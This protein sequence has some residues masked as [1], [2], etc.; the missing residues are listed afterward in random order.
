MAAIQ[1]ST[2]LV[3]GI[4]IQDTVDKLIALASQ[5]KD[6]LTTRTQALQS[7]QVAV[8]QLSSLLVAFQFEV[9]QLGTA[10]LFDSRQVTSSDTSALTAAVSENGS[11]AQGN[12][13]FTPVQTASTQ[14]LLSQSFGAGD[15]I[16]AGTLTFGAGGFVNQG[17][18]LSSLNGGAGVR[19]G[20]IRITDRSG[21]SSVI[22]LSNARTVDDVITAISTNTGIN[23]T[24]SAVGDSFMLTDTSGGSGNLK[25]QEVSGGSTASD[26]G[27]AGINVAASSATGSDVFSLTTKTSLASLNDGTGVQLRS[28]DDLSI[29][30]ADGSTVNVDLASAKTLNDVLNAINAASPT[31]VAA[32]IGSDGNRLQLTDLTTGSG[33][34]S[35]SNVGNGTAASDLGLTTTAAGSTITGRR[36]TSGLSDTLISSLKGGAGLGTLGQIDI[37]TRDGAASQV[38]LS[39]AETLGDIVSA[40]NSQ[41]TGV[42]AQINPARNGITL[43]DT[44]GATTSNFIVSNGDANGTATA[45]GIAVNSTATSVNGG[46]LQKKQISAATLLSSLNGGAGIDLGDLKITGTNGILGDVDLNTTGNEATTVGDV[47]DRIN[48]LT[49]VGV[50]A[51]INDRGDGIEII[52]TAG[53][54]GSY[55]SHGSR[56]RHHRQRPGPA[57]LFNLGHSRWRAQASYRWQCNG[58]GDNRRRRHPER[59]GGQNQCA[60]S[61]RH[62]QLAQRRR[63]AT[64]FDLGEQPTGRP[65]N[66]S[67][68]RA[69]PICRCRKSAAAATRSSATAHPAQ[70]ESWSVRRPIPSKTSSMVST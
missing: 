56:Q 49:G 63:R 66:F 13:L 52:D 25:V 1:S 59:R 65:T 38:N 17:I 46:A 41:A 15:A 58:H 53:G 16:G 55:Q 29:S 42:T 37:T 34:F 33:T 24:A 30:L 64:A 20:Q 26:L 10:S 61:G 14:Q 40:I 4:P 7:E 48:A 9:K 28:G 54:S 67:S 60:Q 39:A 35:V 21:A 19:Q 69:E 43:T 51:R 57:R 32:S 23:V 12:Y 45:L 27:L 68:I 6:A 70:P 11:P 50:E 36:L 3:T 8:T 44:T 47:I 31:T 22:D 5:P 2:G 18:S 62:R